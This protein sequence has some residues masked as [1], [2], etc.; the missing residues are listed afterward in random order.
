LKG[1]K[2]SEF[3]SLIIP[4]IEENGCQF[5]D[6]EIAKEGDIQYLRVYITSDG[7]VSLE[8]CE[9]ISKLISPIL[10]V[11]EPLRGKYFF[12]VSSP[13][14]ERK[15]TKPAHF[16]RSIG[17]QVRLKLVGGEKFEGVISTYEDN[18]ISL[19][20][21]DDTEKIKFDDIKT[22]KTVFNW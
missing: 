12:E 11:N 3:E 9:V 7:G 6:T 19:N 4:I 22:A 21:G 14:I 15:L 20:V 17:A 16:E 5:Y 8:Q 18:S 2:V 13:G 1:L 10:D